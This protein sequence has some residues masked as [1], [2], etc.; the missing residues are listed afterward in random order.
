[1]P[2]SS[3]KLS[4]LFLSFIVIGCSTAVQHESN[5]DMITGTIIYVELEGGFY[6]ISV[7]DSEKYYPLN[8]DASFRQDGLK[9][10]FSYRLAKKVT[11]TVMWGTPVEILHMEKK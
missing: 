7:N 3:F 8:L 6:G 10:R 2:I 11:T 1:M 4:F 9:I 5:K